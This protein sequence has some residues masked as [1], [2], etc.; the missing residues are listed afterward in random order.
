MKPHN[1]AIEGNPM[2]ISNKELEELLLLRA[3]ALLEHTGIRD[4][5]HYGWLDAYNADPEYLGHAI[6][7]TDPPFDWDIIRPPAK[8]PELNPWQKDCAVAQADFS[9]VMTTARLSLGLTAF[10]AE[11]FQS[12]SFYIG[13]LFY[14][15]RMGTVVNLGIASDRIRDFFITSIFEQTTKEYNG[16]G[17]FNAQK[18]CWYQT[19][20]LEAVPL[21]KSVC[22]ALS[23]SPENIVKMSEEIHNFRESRN[24]IIHEIATHDGDFEKR[25]VNGQLPQTRFDGDYKKF[26]E[27]I[28]LAEASHRDKILQVLTDLRHCYELLVKFSS[29]IFVGHYEWRRYRNKHA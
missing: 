14:L 27:S 18:R 15:H 9:G 16:N 22:S 10:H 25:R 28:K 13:E 3:D 12:N 24:A 17:K 20:F 19:P 2:P 8:M 6:I 11:E 7:Q 21:L 29:D 26:Q 1:P 23:F 5:G 4:I